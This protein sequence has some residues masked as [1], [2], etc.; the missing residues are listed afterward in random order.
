MLEVL[1]VYPL[2]LCCSHLRSGS[3]KMIKR[4]GLKVSPCIVF[5]CIG[6][7]CVLS[8]C[9]PINVI[10]DCEYILPTNATASCG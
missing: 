4:Y 10:L 2:F 3:R 5:L 8:K 6:I 9:S 1:K 7:D